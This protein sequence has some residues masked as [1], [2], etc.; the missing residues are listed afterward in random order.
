MDKLE[1]ITPESQ[2]PQHN[3]ITRAVMPYGKCPSCDLYWEN[4]KLVLGKEP[5]TH[6]INFDY[7]EIE[8]RGA[9]GLTPEEKKAIHQFIDFSNGA[10]LGDP[11][12]NC[13]EFNPKKWIGR[14]GD[15]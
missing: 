1:L 5:S 13:E 6:P 2:E 12:G 14:G 11:S 8:V 4:R 3:H 15:E 10:A 9:A 7:G